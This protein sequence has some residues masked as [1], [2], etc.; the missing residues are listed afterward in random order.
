MTLLLSPCDAAQVSYTDTV[1]AQAL[2]CIQRPFDRFRSGRVWD[3]GRLFGLLLGAP[4]YFSDPESTF[5]AGAYEYGVAVRDG[6]FDYAPFFRAPKGALY[7]ERNFL[8]FR[9][10]TNDTKT[11]VAEAVVRVAVDPVGDSAAGRIAAPAATA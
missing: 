9:P 1:K 10:G 2:L 8:L 7:T 11:V 6:C 4:L 5:V 3:G